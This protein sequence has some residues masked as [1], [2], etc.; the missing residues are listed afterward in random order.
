MKGFSVASLWRMKLFCEE[1]SRNTILAPLVR[2]IS[3]SHNVVIMEKC[4]NNLEREFYIRMT[5]KNSWTK[6]VLIHQIEGKAYEHILTNQTN[7]NKTVPAKIRH[8][9]KLA[10]KD[11][12]AFDFLELG[13]QHTERQLEKAVLSRMS[14]FLNEMGGAI[15]FLG[16]QY[17]LEVG[18]QEYFVDILLYHRYLRSL[19]ALEFKVGEFLPEYVGKMQFYLT[20]I[21]KHL[22]AKGENPPIGIIV[23]KSKNKTV[24]EYALQDVKKPIGVSTYRITTRLP[25]NL[26][27]ELPAPEQVVKLLAGV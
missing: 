20:T 17:R 23:C 1:Y 22:K 5:R 16:S 15:S 7:F 27:K 21:N 10:I 14:F 2:E 11:E 9:A 8:Q 4:K 26:K 13:E 18:G 19:I 12:Y 25:K 6:N 24:V 3:W